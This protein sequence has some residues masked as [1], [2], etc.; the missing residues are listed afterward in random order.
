M[1]SSLISRRRFFRQGAAAVVSTAAPV[2][3]PSAVLGMGDRPSPGNRIT[4]AMIGVGSMGLRHVHGFLQQPDCHITA[5]CDVDGVRCAEAARVVNEAYGTSGCRMFGDFR[6]LLA[7]PDIDTVCIAVPDHWHGVLSLAAIRVGKDIYGEKPLA[8]TIVEGRAI[9]DAVRRYGCVWETGSWQRSTDNFRFGCELVRNGRI[10][11]LRRV[12][13]CLGTGPTTGIHP[14]MPVP[15]HLNYEMWLGPA[16]WAPYTEMRCHWN[17]RWIHDYSGGQVTDLGAHHIDIAQ[18]GM[19][20]DDTGP[21]E[22]AGVGQFPTEGLWDA[23]VRYRFECKYANGIEMAVS[24][25]DDFQNGVRFVGDEGWVFVGR[26]RTATEPARLMRE[27][28]GPGE[29]H[30][31]R[32]RGNDRDGHRRSF[33]DCVKH[34]GR[35][36]TPPE[37]GHRSVAIAHLAN[38]AM[39]L[40]R[41]I[42][43]NPEREEIVD[44]A[45]ASRMLRPSLRAPWHL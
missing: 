9:C 8:R 18:W 23:A 43:W 20:T 2:F 33:L 12:E 3:I 40:G 15:E 24:S 14:V 29:I 34:R 25:E 28:I 5:I 30:L 13:V 41:K 22:V 32:P 39:L 37:I 11:R 17:F 10:G 36:M 4:M 26:G 31:P 21:V 44:D 45:S 6:E 38:I 42:R 7:C 19:G 16:P 35:P 1:A 27:R